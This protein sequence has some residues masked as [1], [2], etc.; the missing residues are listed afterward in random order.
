MQFL[1]P[2]KLQVFPVSQHYWGWCELAD[3]G[4]AEVAS[5]L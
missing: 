2:F 4:L 1:G 3:P 5:F